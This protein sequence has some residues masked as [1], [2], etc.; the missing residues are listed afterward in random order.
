VQWFEQEL[1]L[2]RTEGVTHPQNRPFFLTPAIPNG[3]AV[4]LIHGFSATPHEMLPLGLHLQQHNFTVYGI[5]LPGHGTT[6]EDLAEKTAEEWQECVE[7]GY[8]SL[9]DEGFHVNVAGLS[10]GALLTMSLALSNAPEKIILLAPFLR[11]HHILSPFAGLLSYVIPYQKKRISAEEKPFYYQRRPLKGIAQINHLIRQLRGNLE[12]IT[13]PSLVL[14][15][16][17]DSTIAR[18]TALKIYNQLGSRHKKFHCYADDVPHVLTTGENPH[19]N[20]VL[21]RCTTFLENI[22]HQ[23]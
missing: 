13:A 18:G 6:P 22:N 9:L 7:R 5:R 17:G 21:Q 4:L 16:T 19:L 3:Q 8:R 23:R 10:T 11:L 2:A 15:S 1:A 12:A 14:T 20:D